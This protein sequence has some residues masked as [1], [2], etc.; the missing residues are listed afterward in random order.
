MIMPRK[1]VLF[2]TVIALF[3]LVLLSGCATG[4][5][6]ATTSVL[7]SDNG[8]VQL[9]LSNEWKRD[10]QVSKLSILGIAN[11]KQQKYAMVNRTPKSDMAAD[12]TLDDYKK[13]FTENTRTLLEGYEESNLQ[14]TTVDSSPALLFEVTGRTSEIDVHYIAAILE[15]DE[16]YYQVV[17]WTLADNFEANKA[18][19]L[20]VIHAFK[21]L[22]EADA[23]ASAKAEGDATATVW[24]KS[25]DGNVRIKI[26]K[27]WTDAQ[28]LSE[29]ATLQAMNAFKEEYMVVIRENKT[30]LAAGTTLEDYSKAVSDN[31]DAML[32][33]AEVTDSKETLI[34]GN[35]ALQYEIS[36]EIDKLKIVYL[37]TVVS[38]E[39]HYNQVLFWTLQNRM[40]GKRDLFANATS[41]FEAKD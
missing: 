36:G 35:R 13:V 20:E 38:S 8:E 28:K 17:T 10:P 37:V 4:E 1:P 41:T 30:D 12:S 25:E 15:K 33:N 11:R 23:S 40:D 32:E 34:N 21:L 5:N 7:V 9:S 6:E 3:A 24:K 18:S 16:T 22:K 29:D 26:P 2:V 14:Q 27:G 19:M 39:G 31:M